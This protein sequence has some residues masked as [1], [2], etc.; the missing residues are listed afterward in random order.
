MKLSLASQ[1][2]CVRREIAQRRKV[3]P[4]LVATRKMR[5]VEADR[6]IEEMEA[7]LATLEWLQPNEAAI[8][9][10]VEARREARS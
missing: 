10:F 6:H 8:R 7:V 3:Y 1:I 5:Q 2:A 4:R 9:A